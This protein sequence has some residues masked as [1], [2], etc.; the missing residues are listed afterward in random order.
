[1]EVKSAS[2]NFLPGQADLRR[3]WQEQMQSDVLQAEKQP[4]T[5]PG[6][7]GVWRCRDQRSPEWLKHHKPRDPTAGTRE[8][9]TLQGFD[10][11]GDFSFIPKA[12]ASQ[13]RVVISGCSDKTAKD[14]RGQP[15]LLGGEAVPGR[16]SRVDD[17]GR[18]LLH[19]SKHRMTLEG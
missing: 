11:S 17:T 5:S 4:V 1:M 7:G 9:T 18:R 13:Q 14:F 8:G 6:P 15:R 10:N 12:K 3:S 2:L 16:K 19:S